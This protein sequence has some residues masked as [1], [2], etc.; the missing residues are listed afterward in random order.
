VLQK[1][2]NALR[3]IQK[4]G[5]S[6]FVRELH[7]RASNHY[8][9]WRLGVDT[10]G[11]I[12]AGDLGYTSR[13]LHDYAA[14]G[15]RTLYSILETVPIAKSASTFLDYGVGKGRVVVVAAT[16]PFRRVIG[17]E[18]SALLLEAAKD[19][20]K[21]MRHRRAVAVDLY[22]ADAAQYVVPGDVNIIHFFNPFRGEVL[23]D[24][25]N[26]I[27]QSWEQYPRDIYILYMNN[28]HFEAVIANQDWLRRI[29]QADFYFGLAKAVYSCGVYV[30]RRA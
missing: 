24:A 28:E 14:V 11:Y 15:Y 20:V 9:E 13:E 22:Q 2:H 7:Y 29:Y 27:R 30:T 19:N 26:H 8:Y 3:F 17:I 1:F 23:Q 18:L 25:V 4:H 12:E 10:L 6:Q 5:T 21:K 16:F